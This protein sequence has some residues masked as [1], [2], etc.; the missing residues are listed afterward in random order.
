MSDSGDPDINISEI[1]D[2]CVGLYK[3]VSQK[4]YK[5]HSNGYVWDKWIGSAFMLICFAYLFFVAHSY[6]YN[7]NFY[8]CGSDLPDYIQTGQDEMCKNPFYNPSL[9]WRTQEY[10]PPGEYGTKPG[11]LFWSIQYIPI[12]LLLIS[13]GAN[14]IIHNRN[15]R[16]KS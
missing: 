12:I 10:L 4:R 3:K 6:N 14:H 15:W 9:E 13:A 1:K 2:S 5:R 8:Q 16:R 7:L 11:P